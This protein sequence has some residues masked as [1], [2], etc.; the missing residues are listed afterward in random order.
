MLVKIVKELSSPRYGFFTSG[1]VRDLPDDFAAHLLQ[2]GAAEVFIIPSKE[3][4][5]NGTINSDPTGNQEPPT[6]N[7]NERGR[8]VEPV[9]RGRPRKDT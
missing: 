3:A 4:A 7:G 1:T 5:D 6:D 8:V 2:A 9:R